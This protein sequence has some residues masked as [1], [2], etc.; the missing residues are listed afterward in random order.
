MFLGLVLNPL[1]KIGL[2]LILFGL[3]VLV[4]KLATD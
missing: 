2:G 3:L 1:T 4:T